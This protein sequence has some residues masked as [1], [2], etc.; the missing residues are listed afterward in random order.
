M[1]NLITLQ[2]PTCGASLQIAG[3][4]NHFICQYCN[5]N[6]LLDR[7][8]KDM[9]AEEWEN[10]QPV[11]T[12]TTQTKQWIKVAAYEVFLHAVLDESIKKDRVFYIEVEYRNESPAPITCRHDQWV[13]FDRDGY[14][15]EPVM[16]FSFPEL[17]EQTGK[18]YLGVSRII[19]SGMKLRGWLAFRLPSSATT[20]YLQFSGGQPPK[21]VE[22]QLD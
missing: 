16:D 18:R 2:C 9:T 17:Y 14:T 3:E 8:I 6:Y 12:Y 15:Y 4:N 22:F 19:T 10:V 11:T 20:A 13:V 5:N 21:T 1:S 7:K